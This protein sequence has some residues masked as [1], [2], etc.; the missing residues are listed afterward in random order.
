MPD[1]SALMPSDPAGQNWLAGASPRIQAMCAELRERLLSWSPGISERISPRHGQRSCGFLLD[2]RSFVYAVP[3]GARLRL[4]LN[5]RRGELEDPDG[6]AKCT[7]GMSRRGRSDWL[8]ELSDG[9]DPGQA[10]PLVRQALKATKRWPVRE[11]L[12]G[13][14]T[15]RTMTAPAWPDS[16]GCSAAIQDAGTGQTAWYGVLG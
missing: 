11:A 15:W 4:L 2:G 5:L 13:R 3:L 9:R 7:A 10:M 1:P 8:L 6:I 14:R 12:E 16:H